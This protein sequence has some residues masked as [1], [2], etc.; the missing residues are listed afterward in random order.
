M[1]YRDAVL[2]RFYPDKD[3][4]NICTKVLTDQ[5]FNNE[6][7][8]RRDTDRYWRGISEIQT[9][10]KAKVGLGKPFMFQF[11]APMFE[12]EKKGSNGFNPLNYMSDAPWGPKKQPHAGKQFDGSRPMAGD[13]GAV[14]L[15]DN[16]YNIEALEVEYKYKQ[17]GSDQELMKTQ[18]INYCLKVCHKIGFYIQEFFEMQIL[19]MNVEFY[20]DENG[21]IWFFYASDIFAREMKKPSRS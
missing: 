10:L 18:P 21:K 5:E 3:N 19:R 11:T 16:N 17:F 6:F 12:K 14:H 2:F 13:A 15:V 4:S 1:Y 9:T 7:S 8:R 20:Q